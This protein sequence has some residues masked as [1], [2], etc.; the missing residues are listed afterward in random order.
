M[1]K[2]FV[3]GLLVFTTFFSVLPTKK[4]DAFAWVVVKEALKKIIKAIDLQ[5]QKLQNK[6][7]ALQN[8]EKQ[9]ENSL[10]KTKLKEISDWANKQKEL[11]KKYYDELVRV[12]N[13]IALF[14]KVKH[15]IERQQGLVEEYNHAFSLFKQDRHFTPKEINYMSGV[16][17]GILNESVRNMKELALVI[18]SFSTRMSDG[19]RLEL[20]DNIADK[21]EKNL[22]VLRQFNSQNIGISLQRSGSE[23]DR[24]HIKNLYGIISLSN[25]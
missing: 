10:S 4:S 11:Y 7:I 13:T 5:V 25:N 20:I 15:I 21:I 22:S 24:E 23:R 9:I 3:I 12:K 17:T 1:K 6:T 14:Q 2:H 16:Y 8:A 18:N 19:K